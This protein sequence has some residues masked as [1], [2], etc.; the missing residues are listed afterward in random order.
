MSSHSDDTED[1]RSVR[2][3]N[4]HASDRLQDFAEAAGDWFFELDRDLRFICVAQPASGN[5]DGLS[6][7]ALV[8][9]IYWPDFSSREPVEGV[10]GLRVHAEKLQ[11]RQDWQDFSFAVIGNNGERRVICSAAK[12]IFDADGAFAGYRGVGRDVT[13]RT[14]AE[15]R[16]DTVLRTVPDAIMTIDDAASILSFNPAAE[17]LFGYTTSEVLGRNVKI[18]M[19]A[20]YQHEHDAYMASYHRTGVRKIIGIGRQVDGMRKNGEVFPIRLAVD[21]VIIEGRRLFTGVIHDIS[22]LRE[23][24]SLSNRLGV[25]LDRSL[26]EIYIFDANTLHFVQL[27]HGAMINIGYSAEEIRRLT[28]VDIKPNA[29]REQFDALIAP[30]REG[31]E[32]LRVFE[33]QHQRRDGT[34]YPVE[35]HLQLMADETPPVFVA[36]VVDV[37]ETMR[38][39]EL[40]RQS[41][42]MEAIGQLTGGIAHDFNNLLTIILGNNELLANSLE[43]GTRQRKLLDAASSAAQRGA[44]LTGQ[45]LSFARRQPLE[46]KVV[47]INVLVRDMLDMLGRTLGGTIELSTELAPDLGRAKVDPA[48][49]Q[50]AL[51][52]LAIN[53][54]DA[55]PD[56]GRLIIETSNVDLD[57]D[58]ARRR[59]DVEPGSYVRLSV[60]DTGTGIHPEVQK[61]VFEPFFTTKGPGKGTG[62]GLSMVHGFAKQSRGHVDIYS[63]LG[64]GTAISLY[65]PD[66]EGSP[67]ANKNQ[68]A[69]L[70]PA[71]AYN[72]TVLVVEDEPGVRETTVARLEHL[73]Y[74]I[75]EAETGQ[76]ALDTLNAGTHVDVVLTDMIMPG[77]MTG[78]ELVAIVRAQYPLIKVVVA[79]GYAEDIS[80]P[81]DGT[82]WLRKPYT[83]AQLADTLRQL[84]D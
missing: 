23:A 78:A 57:P 66:A 75:I 12:A 50:N 73:G 22:E 8:E 54:R 81:R 41:Q 38:R 72:E 64:Y 35:V 16:L 84:L 2:S 45:L 17:R 31:T 67:V 24:Q 59:V 47:D 80:M 62:L 76:Q 5:V 42:K 21:E 60:R 18:L 79:S 15:A 7:E 55:M 28:P 44:Q 10:N 36:M 14:A 53:A 1:A 69:I 6:A 51:L 43:A 71:T 32:K 49:L 70:E 82:P 39:E 74:H 4:Q 11:L 52:N 26:N 19:P 77:G 29:T 25:I 63:E 30:L 65:L 68:K 37:T 40:L 20:P 56:G 83:L 13:E 9:K 27:N 46:P 34:I 33:D 58:E 61:R 48:Q 3:G